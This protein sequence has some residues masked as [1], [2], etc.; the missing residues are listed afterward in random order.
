[1]KMKKL[2]RVNFITKHKYMDTS[3]LL[4]SQQESPGG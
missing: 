4:E 3:T 2:L 1:M